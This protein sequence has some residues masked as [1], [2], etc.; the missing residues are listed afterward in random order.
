M[1]RRKKAETGRTARRKVLKPKTKNQEEYIKAIEKNDVTFCTGPAGTG[2]T[3]V[4][5]GIACDYL[6]D[7]RVEK[8][9]VTRPVIESGRGL[10]FLPGTFEE[11]IHPY[12]IPVLE[13]ME[14]RL[15]TN[16]V[17]AYRD[18]GK[19]EVV[20][21]EYMRGRNFHNC[22]VVLD[23]AQNATFEQLKMF[24]TRI[25]WD[26]KAVINGDIDQTDL[27]KKD[28]GGLE[29][30]LDRLSDV[31][32]VGISELTQDDIIRNEIISRILNALYD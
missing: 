3:A 17:Q 21:L 31:E 4:A 13:E 32:G 18:E 8:L 10:G 25:G 9:V 19:I 29:E 24:V 26:S 22:F 23:E 5:V 28:Q 16:R 7:K 27:L 1:A 15:N 6:L 2:K 14:F 20:P 11:K 30:F 12:L